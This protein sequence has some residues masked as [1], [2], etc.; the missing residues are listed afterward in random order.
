[1]PILP[2]VTAHA[3]PR[4]FTSFNTHAHDIPCT[5]DVGDQYQVEVTETVDC[6]SDAACLSAWHPAQKIK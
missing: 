6:E 1:L 5:R 2:P 4:G 3:H